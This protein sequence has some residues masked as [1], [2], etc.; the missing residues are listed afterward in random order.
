VTRRRRNRIRKMTRAEK[1][2]RKTEPRLM[3]NEKSE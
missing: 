1:R 3:K 2:K